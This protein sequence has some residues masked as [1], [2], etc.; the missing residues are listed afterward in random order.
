M[1]FLVDLFANNVLDYLSIYFDLL[2]IPTS[3]II[4]QQVQ[5]YVEY[6]VVTDGNIYNT[7]ASFL[8]TSNSDLIFQHMRIYFAQIINGVRIYLMYFWF[9]YMIDF[10]LQTT[11]T[12][13]K[14]LTSVMRIRSR[15]TQTWLFMCNLKISSS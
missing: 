7:Q 9:W 4:A 13:T 10:N 1:C 5:A 6:M 15:Q 8:Q 14:R 2:R 11:T 3:L 12:I